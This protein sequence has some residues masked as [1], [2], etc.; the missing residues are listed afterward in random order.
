MAWIYSPDHYFFV[1]LC[2]SLQHVGWRTTWASIICVAVGKYSHTYFA[3]YLFCLSS[4]AKTNGSWVL[5]SKETPFDPYALAAVGGIQTAQASH[6]YA[7]QAVREK[8]AELRRDL[9]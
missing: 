1:Q 7:M 9:L 3:C 5:T 6:A 2:L 8:M 4:K